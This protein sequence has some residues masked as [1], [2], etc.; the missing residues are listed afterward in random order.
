MFG[1]IALICFVGWIPILA[2]GYVIV[3]IIETIKG[4]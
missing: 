1:I 2:I 3:M 4:R